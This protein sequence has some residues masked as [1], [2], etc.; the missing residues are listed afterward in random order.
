M[1]KL[2]AKNMFNL[3]EEKIEFA[4]SNKDFGFGRAKLLVLPLLY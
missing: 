3:D 2:S 4:L 1:V